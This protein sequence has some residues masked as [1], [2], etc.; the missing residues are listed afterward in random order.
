MSA[1]LS[2]L[3]GWFSRSEPP[4]PSV[5]GTG[6]AASPAR[7]QGF[8]QPLLWVT[9]ALLAFGLVMVY[10]ASIAMPDNPRFANYAPTFFLS[11]HVLSLAIGLVVAL[12]VVQA[13]V[14][15]WE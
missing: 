14:A 6:Y 8:D 10:S 13:P 1:V 4:I 15:F 11:R 7:V 5:R 9:V 12:A 3:G 2:R